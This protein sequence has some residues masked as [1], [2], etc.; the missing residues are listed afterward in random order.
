MNIRW[1]IQQLF[2][3]SL[4][5]C[6]QAA[7]VSLGVSDKGD[8]CLSFKTTSFL[9]FIYISALYVLTGPLMV[10]KLS[11]DQLAFSKRFYPLW[12]P[13]KSSMPNFRPILYDGF[14]LIPKEENPRHSLPDFPSEVFVL[15]RGF[16]I[17]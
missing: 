17:C 1:T 16:F 15:D 13:S 11:P 7:Y 6:L 4:P 8:S 5:T 2:V 9:R 10:I 14:H 3:S 12:W